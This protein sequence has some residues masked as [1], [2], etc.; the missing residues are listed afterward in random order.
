MTEK[1]EA[2]YAL[3]GASWVRHVPGWLPEPDEWVQDLMSELTWK[4][5]YLQMFGRTVAQP[6][7]TAVC[8]RS[9]D[10][11]SG[12]RRPNEFVPWSVTAGRVAAMVGSEVP[13]WR[14]NGVIGNWYRSGSDSIGFHADDEPALG[15]DPVVVSVSLGAT[16]RF[17]LKPKH[18]DG[19]GL[20]LDLG[21][22]DLLVMGGATQREFVHGIAKSK[23]VTEPRLSLTFRRYL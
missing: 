21:H 13:G 7:L 12:Y 1:N 8:G 16:R 9:M 14:P 22:G 11:V 20:F 10:P 2:H 6:R 4:V 18:G 17:R 3:S 15:P 5:E 23:R 19:P